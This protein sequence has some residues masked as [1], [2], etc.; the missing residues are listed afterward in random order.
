MKL[1][2]S[3]EARFAQADDEEIEAAVLAVARRVETRLGALGVPIVRID[4][5]SRGQQSQTELFSRLDAGGDGGGAQ[6]D[7]RQHCVYSVLQHANWQDEELGEQYE[8]DLQELLPALDFSGLRLDAGVGGGG[9][10]AAE[11]AEAAA[12]EEDDDDDD[13]AG[14]E[15]SGDEWEH[16]ADQARREELIWEASET[17]EELETLRAEKAQKEAYRTRAREKLAAGAPAPD[18]A[19]SWQAVI[20]QLD[21]RLLDI[22]EEAPG[23]Y[24]RATSAALRAGKPLPDPVR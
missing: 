8:Y 18:W 2:A 19:E 14:E 10:R 24:E 13:D 7:D 16:S 1:R 22:I 9:W 20:D 17:R 23:S 12:E 3:A 5:D 11:R 15:S 4:E 21:A 6:Y